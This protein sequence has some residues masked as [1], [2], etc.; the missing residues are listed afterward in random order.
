VSCTAVRG[1]ALDSGAATPDWPRAG[2][3]GATSARCPRVE[4]V[5]PVE[6]LQQLRSATAD[7]VSAIG[8]LSD[9]DARAP[10]RLPGWTRGHVLTHLAR[11][12]EGGTRLL[13]WARTGVPSYEY[14]SLTARAA[15][16]EQGAG[17][18]AAALIADLRGSADGFFAA[19]DGV[20]AHAWQRTV[21]WTTGQ[22]TDAAL[23]VPM[24]LGEVLIHQV[25]LDI[26]YKPR[27]WP[28][29]F[30]G[31]YLDRA[32]NALRRHAEWP[33]GVRMEATDTGRVHEAGDVA[34]ASPVIAGPE[35]A[36]LAWL[37]ARSALRGIERP[38]LPRSSI[39][40][41]QHF[42]PRKQG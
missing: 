36:L 25:D 20:P 32:V 6:Y 26:G 35:Y 31:D 11:N 39:Q 22:E 16:I 7:L 17:R 41:P 12:A 3:Q 23:I 18:P 1:R 13:D 21:R 24:R 2:E 9:A 34:S 40:R 28:I 30:V 15:A 5:T 19:A 8:G 42:N 38:R 10:S 37:L 14:E 27:D 29:A 33:G 4:S